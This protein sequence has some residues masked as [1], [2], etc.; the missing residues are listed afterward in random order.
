M[1]QE[2]LVADLKKLA[3]KLQKSKG[4]VA[5]L[6]LLAP[7]VESE[8]AWNVI[9]SAKGFDNMSRANAIKQFTQLLRENVN[10]NNWHS[11]MRATVLKTDDPFVKAINRTFNSQG[12]VVNIQSCNIFGVEIPK[13]ILFQLQRKAA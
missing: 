8:D 6:M 5:L 7:D 11:I 3:G 13:A 4:P 2:V 9:V 10:K 1:D 12:P